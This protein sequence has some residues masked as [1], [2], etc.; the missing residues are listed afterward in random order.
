MIAPI[1]ITICFFIA[2]VALSVFL[3]WGNRKSDDA[4]DD[5]QLAK[6]EY[7]QALDAYNNADP[8]YIDV[9]IANVEAAK[10]RY[11]GTIRAAREGMT[12]E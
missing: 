11:H 1:L 10:S 5:L 4:P 12:S 7:C 2:L 3:T 6:A 8:E 9:A